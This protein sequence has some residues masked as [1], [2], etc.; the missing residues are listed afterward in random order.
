MYTR[1]HFMESVNGEHRTSQTEKSIHKD[2]VKKNNAIQ[3]YIAIK[4]LSIYI[5]IGIDEVDCMC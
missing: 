2:T 3:Q 5:Y 1:V 4:I